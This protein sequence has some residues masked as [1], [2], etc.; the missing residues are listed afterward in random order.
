MRKTRRY[1]LFRRSL[2]MITAVL[3]LSVAASCGTADRDGQGAEPAP[4]GS[5]P[6]LFPEVVTAS[7]GPLPLGQV[8]Y[9][10]YVIQDVPASA[11]L[12]ARSRYQMLVLEPT[13]T[14]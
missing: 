7:A 6:A 8:E 14:D 3:L 9:W 13:R 11:D 12:L 1:R 2:S 5:E 4:A 10:A